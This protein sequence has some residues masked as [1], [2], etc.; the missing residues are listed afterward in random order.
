MMHFRHINFDM[1]S[2]F[3]CNEPGVEEKVRVGLINLQI[4]AY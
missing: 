3:L 2:R 4:S 1:S